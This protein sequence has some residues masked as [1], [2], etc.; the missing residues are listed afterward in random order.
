LRWLSD[1]KVTWLQTHGLDGDD[2]AAMARKHSVSSLFAAVASMRCYE[3]EISAVGLQTSGATGHTRHAAVSTCYQ[4]SRKPAR[5]RT[6]LRHEGCTE[7]L[8]RYNTC[9]LAV[10]SICIGFDVVGCA[11]FGVY[12]FRRVLRRASE[13]NCDHCG[14]SVDSNSI[15]SWCHLPSNY[16]VCEMCFMNRSGREPWE[17]PFIDNLRG[18]SDDDEFAAQY[19]H[20][21]VR[22]VDFDSHVHAAEL[23]VVA[24]CLHHVHFI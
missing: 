11:V 18:A 4:P 24:R 15:A 1:A 5:V 13:A 9:V 22:I 14:E 6:N 19:I 23:A 7:V 16:D 8:E 2:C 21:Q 17:I 20:L 3:R 12:P 10:L